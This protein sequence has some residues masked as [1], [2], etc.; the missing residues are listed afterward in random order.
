MI[1]VD[2]EACE[3]SYRVYRTQG[4]L[5]SSELPPLWRR[6]TDGSCDRATPLGSYIDYDA[7]VDPDEF[8]EAVEVI[9]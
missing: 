2:Y 9:E 3:S 7:P 1:V 8:V 4:P 6:S 5:G